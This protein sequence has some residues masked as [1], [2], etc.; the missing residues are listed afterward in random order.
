MMTPG[1]D[2]RQV[3]NASQKAEKDQEYTSSSE[4]ELS[5]S[6]GPDELEASSSSGPSDSDSALPRSIDILARLAPLYFTCF[7]GRLT[8]A[9]AVVSIP[10]YVLD[11]GGSAAAGLHQ[12]NFRKV[13]SMRMTII[14]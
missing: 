7:L 5:S 6:S 11:L 4:P 10:L 9:L 12:L 1:P 13:R 14:G 3:Q 8:R 2:H